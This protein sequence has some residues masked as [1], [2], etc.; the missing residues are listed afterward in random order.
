MIIV[1]WLIVVYLVT[2]LSY[3]NQSEN[4]V[5]YRCGKKEVPKSMIRG[6]TESEQNEWPWLA[7]LVYKSDDENKNGMFFCAATLI[8]RKSVL[9]AAHCVQEKFRQTRLT[10]SDFEVQVGRHNLSDPDEL[11]KFAKVLGPII[12]IATHPDWNPT[13]YD[14]Y[15]YDAD[16]ALLIAENNIGSSP[17]IRP[18]CLPDHDALNVIGTT[19]GWGFTSND[20][21]DTEDYPRQAEVTR[22][23]PENCF[24]EENELGIISSNRTFCVKGI[25]GNAGPCRADSGNWK[26]AINYDSRLNET[27]IHVR[28]WILC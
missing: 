28:R 21:D 13:D 27:F 26:T 12:T 3:A 4:P 11:K 24:L 2:G 14:D 25:E 16:V 1:K 19:V 10:V 18:I 5:N 6:G 9:T 8:S 20:E 7:N 23:S 17:F 15:R 22:V